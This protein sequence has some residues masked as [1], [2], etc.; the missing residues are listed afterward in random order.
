MACTF[1]VGPWL[2]QPDLNSIS[3]DDSSVRLEP[4]VMEVL[5]CLASQAGK[6]LSKETLLK[7]VWTDTFVSEYVLSRSISEL[8]RILKDDA[9]ESRYIETIPKRG[10]RL[11]APVKFVEEFDI[12]DVTEPVQGTHA[13]APAQTSL[14]T[15]IPRNY[16]IAFITTFSGIAVLV[17]LGVGLD[18]GG[19]STRLR[20][21]LTKVPQIHSLAVLPLKNL[22]EDPSQ[23]YFSYGMT[24][25]LITDLAQIAGLKVISHTS[26]I[27]YEKS[28]KSLPQIARE[29]GVDGIVEGTVQ[30]SGNRVRITAQL[31]YAPDEQHL[32]AASYDRDLQDVLAL[33]SSVAAA[34]IE[35]IRAKTASRTS[36]PQARRSSPPPAALEAYLRGNYSLQRMGAGDG[37]EGYQSAVMY[38][39]QAI[40]EDPNFAAAYEKL[41]ETYDANYAW[42]PNEITP[43]QRATLAKALELD[44]ES[45]DAHLLN[46]HIKTNFDCDLAG[47][48]KEYKEALR[49]NPNLA[50]AHEGYAVDLYVAGRDAE[51]QQEAQRAHELDPVRR[52]VPTALVG[53]SEYEQEIAE[54]QEHLKLHPDDGFAYIDGGLIDAYHFAGRHRESAEALQRAWTLFGFKDIGVGVRRAYAAS[55][56]AA[57]LRYSAIQMERLY[58]ER[59]VYKPY[60]IAQWYARV[61]DKEQTFKWIK[62]D[63][64]DNNNCWA[65]LNREPDFIILHN[66]PRFQ[67]LLKHAGLH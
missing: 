65:G 18:V 45:A 61:G 58:G 43:L 62:I 54:L 48:D 16:K 46:A 52:K 28:S 36:A 60:M 30:H 35:P 17:G 38:F 37:Y 11:I 15:S 26:V 31:I 32:W 7:S 23:D 33:Q 8:R 29:L 20:A 25:E 12:G 5:V 49:L 14:Q 55:G 13:I 39:K 51:G 44:P 53:A 9:R 57:A 59:K 27:Q 2:V 22:S 63:L 21:A 56:Y 42:R 10:Y 24:E 19:V 4:K 67:D 34:I 6:P 50:S 47:A 1:R 64:A 66:D 3:C 40:S 41:A